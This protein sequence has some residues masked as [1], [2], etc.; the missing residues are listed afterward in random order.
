[1]PRVTVNIGQK[2]FAVIDNHAIECVINKFHND[3]NWLVYRTDY[4]TKLRV[5]YGKDVFLS[6][7][8]AEKHIDSQI[9]RNK[10]LINSNLENKLIERV[11][12]C[13][14]CNVSFDEFG[15]CKCS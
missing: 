3:V 7:N 6:R 12:Y 1:M 15:R 14:S 11:P 8:K 9:R 5:T 10:M 2:V 4:F 13:D